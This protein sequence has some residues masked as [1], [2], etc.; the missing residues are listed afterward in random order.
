MNLFKKR[1]CAGCQFLIKFMRRDDGETLKFTLN[2]QEREMIKNGRF[3]DYLNPI[4]ALECERGHWSE[5]RGT[6]K[7]NRY[8]T[9][10]E[11][12]RNNCPDYLEVNYQRNLQASKRVLDQKKDDKKKIKNRVFEVFLVI[13]TAILTFTLTT[14]YADEIKAF[15]E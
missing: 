4:Y 14:L 7:K 9:I 5:G 2:S 8:A 1:R 6:R 3:E 12:T 10:W 15:F 13:L 11:E